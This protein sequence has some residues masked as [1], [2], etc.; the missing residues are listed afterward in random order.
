MNSLDNTFIMFLCETFKNFSLYVSSDR[1]KA[2]FRL[3]A[4]WCFFRSHF[5]SNRVLLYIG[6]WAQSLT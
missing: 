5:G 3:L 4:L 2:I 6:L 1:I